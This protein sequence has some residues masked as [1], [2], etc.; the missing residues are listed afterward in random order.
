MQ[1]TEKKII[2]LTGGI[3][4]GKSTVSAFLRKKGIEVIDL[5]E[6][7][8]EI[9]S[10]YPDLPDRLEKELGVSLRNSSGQFDKVLLKE[11]IFRNRSLK[12]KVEQLLHPLIKEEFE[13]RVAK[14]K[15]DTV[16]CEAALLI[17]A[18]Y[19]KWIK[20]LVVVL[21][22]EKV[23]KER[24]KKRDGINEFLIAD[25]VRSQVDDEVRKAKATY[26]ILN[27]GDMDHLEYQVEDM[28]DKLL[29]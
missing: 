22:P 17:E 15:A 14:S 13:K 8:R 16:V 12:E 24:V 5:D 21:A 7:G 4:A 29:R 6:V 19:D 1:K 23:R 18:N 9:Y 10:L 2:G 28:I 25:I 27:D 11:A 20:E 3:G 26:V